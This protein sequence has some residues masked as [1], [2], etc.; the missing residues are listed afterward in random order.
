MDGLGWSSRAG[1]RALAFAASKASSGSGVPTVRG[2]SRRTARTTARRPH[3]APGQ[4][5]SAP[6]E[7]ANGSKGTQTGRTRAGHGRR[8]G[9]QGVRRTR[10]QRRRAQHGRGRGSWAASMRRTSM[11][12][13]P[14]PPRR[15]P[16]PPPAPSMQGVGKRSVLPLLPLPPLLPPSRLPQL[17]VP[18]RRG[19]AQGVQYRTASG[20]GGPSPGAR[21]GTRLATSCRR[22]PTWPAGSGQRS[23]V[24]SPQSTVNGC[25][26]HHGV[27]ER[28]ARGCGGDV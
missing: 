5:T 24:S 26:P 23:T 19:A 6:R 10:A 9:V 21:K 16:P 27:C 20:S 4:A 28:R 13:L 7:A 17:P 22:R 2:S 25:R 12:E 1:L 11:T 18:C 3:T 15:A 8:W 14:R